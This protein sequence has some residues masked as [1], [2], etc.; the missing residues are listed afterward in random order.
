M[1]QSRC[2]TL[3]GDSN[4]KN[5][6]SLNNTRDRPLMSG[7][8]VIQCG[9][10]SLLSSAMKSIRA[11][12]NVCVLSCVT[13]F[14]VNASGSSNVSLKV[15]SV[16]VDF[17]QK[18]AEVATSKPEIEFLICPPMYR[19]AP[20]W[21]R[22]G[23]PEVLRKFSE[24]MKL[25]PANCHLMPSFPNPTLEDDG[26]HL[27]AYSGFEFALHL[28]DSLS[29]VLDSLQLEPEAK[30]LVASESTRVLEDR[31]MVLEQDHRRLNRKFEFKTAVDA[32]LSDFQENI[33][34]ESFLMIQG[35]PRLPKLEPKEWQVQAKAHVQ[36]VLKIVM[37]KE[38]PVVYVKNSTGRGKDAKI[39][40]R[41]KMPSAQISKEIR[42]KF[43]DFFL[44]SKNTR[45][46]ELKPYSIRN[47]VTT[48]TL[49]RIA[50]LQLFGTRYVASNPGSKYKVVGYEPR[51][52]LKITPSASSTDKR[53][54]TYDYIEAVTKLPAS[55][56]K[57][58]IEALFKRISPKLYGN[59]KPLLVVVSDDM[60]KKKV[61]TKAASKSSVAKDGGTSGSESSGSFK[62]PG[63]VVSRTLKRGASSE[64]LSEPSSKSKSKSRP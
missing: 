11:E 18:V 55:F 31:V 62:S 42:D 46:P 2:V 47:A 34:N 44:G 3:V 29:S 41:V 45:P 54:Q 56:T 43:G 61:F 9:R 7:A 37:G 16:F 10:M 57:S 27:T 8:Q 25:R 63:S 52:L 21:Y 17:L 14:A 35:L 24:V 23:L 26:V 51:P 28:F 12:S 40:Y 60:V 36:D 53:I 48:A 64:A 49:A 20:I 30:S 50:I 5:H 22:E 4:I 58:E 59:L 1:A 15:E 38:C 13:N 39:T 19:L 32:E 6:M 33:R